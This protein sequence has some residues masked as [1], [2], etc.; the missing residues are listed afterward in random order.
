YVLPG[1]ALNDITISTGQQDVVL[2]SFKLLVP[3]GSV[4]VT[5]NSLILRASNSDIQRATNLKLYIDGGTRGVLDNRDI[6]ISSTADTEALTF[7]F[8]PR[9]F[10]PDLPMWFIVVGD[11]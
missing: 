5:V 4:S 6:L 9:T 7:T 1:V 2:L 11:F 8:N 3:E 10:Q